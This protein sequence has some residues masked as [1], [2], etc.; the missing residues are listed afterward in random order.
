MPKTVDP[1][2][3]H[4]EYTGARYLIKALVKS[5]DDFKLPIVNFFKVKVCFFNRLVT[6]VSKQTEDIVQIT[7]SALLAPAPSLPSPPAPAVC[8][9][10]QLYSV[11]LQR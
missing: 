3:L 9:I 8:I 5:L 1:V 2:K 7:F 11:D 6:W 10:Y 4:C